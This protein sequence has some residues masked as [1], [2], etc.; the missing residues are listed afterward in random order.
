[1]FDGEKLDVFKAS[2]FEIIALEISKLEQDEIKAAKR[3]R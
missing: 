2:C 3:K 1:V